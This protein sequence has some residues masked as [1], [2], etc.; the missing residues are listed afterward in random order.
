[1]VSMNWWNAVLPVVTLV[2]GSIRAFWGESSRDNRAANRADTER[3]AG[4]R[5]Q[6]TEERRAFELERRS[7]PAATRF[8][9]SGW[10]A[11]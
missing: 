2:L 10:P 11:T 9:L 5:A 8:A 3:G 6:L 7:R 1:M 4:H